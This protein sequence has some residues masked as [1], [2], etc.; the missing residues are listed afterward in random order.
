MLSQ[1]NLKL[2]LLSMKK[3]RKGNSDRCEP[4]NNTRS[5]GYWAA[6]D[7]ALDWA[8]ANHKNWVGQRRA[9][10]KQS[11]SKLGWKRETFCLPRREAQAKAREFFKKY[12]KAAYWSEVE[13]WRELPEDVIEFTMR[14]L[15]SAD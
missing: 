12:P 10:A 13:N 7:C 8:K 15:P 5:H 14:R 4:V 6:Q 3:D 11:E 1:V 9:S 2:G